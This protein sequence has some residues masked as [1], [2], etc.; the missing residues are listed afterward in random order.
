MRADIIQGLEMLI[1]EENRQSLFRKYVIESL[2]IQWVMAGQ[3][4]SARLLQFMVGIQERFVQELSEEENLTD[5]MVNLIADFNDI[6]KSLRAILSDDVFA[7]LKYVESVSKVKNKASQAVAVS[8]P[9]WRTPSVRC[10]STWIA[11]ALGSPPHP[12]S[13]SIAAGMTSWSM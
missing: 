2:V 9:W 11:S 12:R 10:L 8:L 1:T 4:Q 7:T 5:L 6:T 13:S 3:S